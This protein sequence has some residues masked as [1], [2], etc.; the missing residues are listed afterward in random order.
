MKA[1][2]TFL[3]YRQLREYGCP[4]TRVHI[5]RLINAGGFPAPYQLSDNR[6]G[7]RLSDVV[8]WQKTR[9]RKEK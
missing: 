8:A 5:N 2:Q 7:W 6:I 1:I 3:S 9:V 4:W